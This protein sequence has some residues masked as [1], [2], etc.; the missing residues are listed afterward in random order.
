MLNRL[1]Q[2]DCSIGSQLFN[3]LALDDGLGHI[4]SIA[5]GEA[6]GAGYAVLGEKTTASGEI[7]LVGAQR[8]LHHCAA[9]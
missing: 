1:L 5:Y 7:K 2:G 3:K 6:G 8:R 9:E 4:G